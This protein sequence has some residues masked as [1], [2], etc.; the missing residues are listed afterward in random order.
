MAERASI[1]KCINLKDQDG[2]GKGRTY[3]HRFAKDP[4]G[5]DIQ[6]IALGMKFACMAIT[7]DD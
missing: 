1:K 4:G 7:D 2:K 5:I 3:D 6:E